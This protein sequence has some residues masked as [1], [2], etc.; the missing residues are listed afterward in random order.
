MVL[1]GEEKQQQRQQQQQQQFFQKRV[2]KTDEMR[3]RG[4]QSS[5]HGTE[6]EKNFVF[7]GPWGCYMCLF[8]HTYLN[9]NFRVG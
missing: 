3:G 7:P 2:P 1:E 4:V 9:G 6:E 8:V 5:M